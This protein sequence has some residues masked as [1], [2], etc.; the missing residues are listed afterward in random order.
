MAA[1]PAPVS[2]GPQNW[3]DALRELSTISAK[4][5]SGKVSWGR[6]AGRKWKLVE[7]EQSE[8]AIGPRRGQGWFRVC[9]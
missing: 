1:R 3:E 4:M 7:D 5:A 2:A 9:R 8:G 6:Q